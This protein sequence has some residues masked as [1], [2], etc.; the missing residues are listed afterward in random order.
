MEMPANRALCFVETLEI[1]I[2]FR[3]KLSQLG[4]LRK[5]HIQ[6]FGGV[7]L[8][9]ILFLKDLT[10]PL[11]FYCAHRNA[12]VPETPQLMQDL[13]GATRHKKRCA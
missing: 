2:L 9:F 13:I 10:G 4:T 8:S 3:K 7:R 6:L 12:D 5:K 11:P 1:S